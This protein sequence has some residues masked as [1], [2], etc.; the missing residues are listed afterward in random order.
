[1]DQAGRRIGS[2]VRGRP[3]TDSNSP[4]DHDV[5]LCDDLLA[6]AIPLRNLIAERSGER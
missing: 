6:P 2:I 3:R 4:S 5:S 1:M